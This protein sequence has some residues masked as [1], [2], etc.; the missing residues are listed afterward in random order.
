MKEA[1]LDV[2][3]REIGLER[4]QKGLHFFKEVLDGAEVDL[5]CCRKGLLESLQT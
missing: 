2:D 5:F 3:E 4:G 1:D